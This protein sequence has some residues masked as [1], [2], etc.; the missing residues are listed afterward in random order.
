MQLGFEMDRNS[1]RDVVYLSVNNS[2]RIQNLSDYVL[3]Y[4]TICVMCI[5]F[6]FDVNLEISELMRKRAND[7]R[8]L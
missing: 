6:V 3:V 8:I 1:L 5:R 4:R 2:V 7:K